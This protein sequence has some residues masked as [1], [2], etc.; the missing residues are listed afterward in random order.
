[1][2][3]LPGPGTE[4]ESP[5]LAGGFFTTGALGK[6]YFFSLTLFF[7]FGPEG[8][9]NLPSQGSNLCLLSGMGGALTWTTK[10]VSS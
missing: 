8:I 7:S 9:W 10:D 4:P 2:W 5:S 1:M 3:D 6:S